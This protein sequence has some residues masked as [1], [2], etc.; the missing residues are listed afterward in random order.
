[1]ENNEKKNGIPCKLL[2]QIFAILGFIGIVLAILYIPHKNPSI[3]VLLSYCFS[4]IFW[5]VL[6][7]IMASKEGETAKRHKIEGIIIIV[8]AIL[9]PICLFAYALTALPDIAKKASSAETS[10]PKVTEKASK[11]DVKANNSTADPIYDEDEY[12]SSD[13]DKENVPIIYD[14]EDLAGLTYEDIYEEYVP[15]IDQETEDSKNEY[16]VMSEGMNEDEQYDL[17]EKLADNIN[18]VS[19][20]GEDKMSQLADLNSDTSD[21]Y[22]DWSGKLSNYSYQKVNEFYDLA[23]GIDE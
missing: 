12:D 5:G 9:I 3:T 18:K 15:Q 23:Y 2:A 20:E 11:D 21:N 10:K 22:Y 13:K 16:K 4:A 8:L 6:A 7:I 17:A 14:E 19:E 1:M